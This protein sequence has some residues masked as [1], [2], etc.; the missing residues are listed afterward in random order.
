VLK[1]PEK[2]WLEVVTAVY[3][4]LVDSQTGDGTLDTAGRREGRQP[5]DVKVTMRISGGQ[6]LI[7]ECHVYDASL[8]TREAVEEAMQADV[9]ASTAV[10]NLQEAAHKCEAALTQ[11]R[12]ARRRMSEERKRK[13]DD[14]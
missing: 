10:E 7:S 13:R 2:Y 1:D 9:A 12:K 5:G 6:Q 8:D 3:Q 11:Q 14:P 4:A